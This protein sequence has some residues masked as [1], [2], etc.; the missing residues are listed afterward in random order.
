MN[1]EVFLNLDRVIHEKGRLAI[2]SLLA[3]VNSL[4]FTEIRDILGMTDGNVS[5]H[6]KTLRQAEY[7][8]ITK[9]VKNR[10]PLTTVSLTDEGKEAF[11]KYLADLDQI[12][13][14]SPFKSTRENKSADSLTD[15]EFGAGNLGN[16]PV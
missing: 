16:V 2:I 8:A 11:Q 15:D 3:S 13:Q 6:L 10:K 7:V 5:V 4:S 12:V 1:P 9:R 14:S